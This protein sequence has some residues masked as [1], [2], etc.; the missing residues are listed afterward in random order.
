MSNFLIFELLVKVGEDFVQC[1]LFQT[2]ERAEEEQAKLNR[3]RF[4][5][6]YVIKPRLVEA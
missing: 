6:E 3:V 4:P 2:E 5:V 1:G